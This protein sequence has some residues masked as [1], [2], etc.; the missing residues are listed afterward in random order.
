MKQIGVWLNKD[1]AYILSL[2]NEIESFVT[3]S[4]KV[5]INLSLRMKY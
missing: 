4:S 5:E 1:N 3:V 2:E